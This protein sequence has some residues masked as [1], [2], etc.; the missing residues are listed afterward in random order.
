VFNLLSLVWLILQIKPQVDPI[1]LHYNILFGVDFIGPWWQI[2]FLPAIG[3]LI[4]IINT[5][6]SWLFFQK[7]KFGAYLL[8]GVA[9]LCEIFLFIA[10]VLLVFLNV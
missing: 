2:F 6:L 4:L 9:L 3:L 5:V 8:L 1:F 10:T 7:D